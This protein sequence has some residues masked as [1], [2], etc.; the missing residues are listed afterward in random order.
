MESEFPSNSKTT[1]TTKKSTDA[2]DEP[3]KVE[4]VVTGEV[5]TR[6]RP[7][8]RRFADTFAGGDARGAGSYVLFD[9]M[10]PAAKDMVADAMSQGVERMLFGEV[11][12]TSRRGHRTGASGGY[13][14]Y[15]R[16][17]SGPIG[18]R[19]EEPRVP[20]RRN[21]ALHNFDEFIL[22]TRAEAHEVLDRLHHRID[23]YEVAT[24]ADLYDLLGQTGEYT[25]AKWGWTD[26]RYADIT[27]ITNGYVLDLPRPEPID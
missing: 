20:S 26:L 8:G 12:S 25:D 24:V 4:K 18:S 15:N 3:K 2:K 11:R 16:M 19:R 9:V 6:K 23:Q 21:R 5:R 22:D 10:I 17:G 1:K 27:R 13:T 7:L 14:P